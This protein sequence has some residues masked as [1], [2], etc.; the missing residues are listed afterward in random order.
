[1]FADLAIIIVNWNLK[2]DTLGCIASLV[3]S[4]ASLNQ[5][6]VVDN[7]STDGS[8][9]ALRESFGGISSIIELKENL[10][11]AGGVN[12]GI[13]FA[14]RGD[15]QWLLLINN[16]TVVAPDFIEQL[17]V[18]SRANPGY[19]IF[20]P[21][22]L[23]HDHPSTVWSMGDKQI[24]HTLLSKP[25]YKDNN[26]QRSFPAIIPI[27][28]ANG[29]AMMVNRQVFDEIGFLDETLFMYG[30]EVDFCWCARL[31]GFSL[32]CVPSARMWHKI[33][34]SSEN[35]KPGVQYRKIKNQILFYR[36]YACGAQQWPYFAYTS[37]RCLALLIIDIVKRRIDLL[38]PTLRG[39]SDGWTNSIPKVFR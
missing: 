13:H 38:T 27:D 22:I 35:D 8:A 34:K 1:M 31:A 39:W 5:I 23:Y 24:G 26:C 2:E 6:V 30:E 10:G 21:M 33:S 19:S 36:R 4:G 28:F 3:K 16:D 25:L 9:I 37:I 32:A 20:S 29:C 15:S 18:T 7:G 14:L 12:R 11:Y 17:L